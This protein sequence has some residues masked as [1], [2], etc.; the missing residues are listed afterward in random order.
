MEKANL[1]SVP[2]NPEFFAICN[3]FCSKKEGLLQEIQEKGK[4]L[5]KMP[6]ALIGVFFILHFFVL[7]GKSVFGQR[8]DGINLKPFSFGVSSSFDPQ[9]IF[10]SVNLDKSFSKYGLVTL[11]Q[12]WGLR[13]TFYQRVPLSKTAVIV[14]WDF[15]KSPFWT[16]APGAR[17]FLS[18]INLS[19]FNSDRFWYQG[20]EFGF[21]FKFGNKLKLGTDIFIGATTFW[22]SKS[23]RINSLI[24]LIVED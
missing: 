3:D 2:V 12:G 14:G 18:T 24:S 22:V 11:Y 13:R 10:S 17:L 16:L 23:S 21:Q 6:K 4:P 5:Q 1:K 9:D 20:N 19:N 15:I 7:S 8:S